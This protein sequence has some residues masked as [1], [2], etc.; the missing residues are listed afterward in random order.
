MRPGDRVG[1]A[2]VSGPLTVEQADGMLDGVRELGFEPV[3][4]ANLRARHDLFAGRDDERLTGLHE[5]AADPTLAAVVFARGGH[6][7]LPLLPR[8]DWE[9]LVA[10]PRAWVGYSD[11]T[12]F[13]LQWS[14]RSGY[15]AFH[16]PMGVDVARGLLPEER[17][18]LLASL[19]GEYPQV[20]SARRAI[21]GPEPARAPVAGTL[22]GGCLSLLAS[23]L[24]TPWQVGFEGA[25]L[26]LEDV[27]EPLYRIDRM[28]TH[29]ALSGSL[30]GVLGVVLGEL[31]GC[32][33]EGGAE[34]T[35]VPARVRRLL[36]EVPVL[37][38]LEFGHG[39]PNR[40]LPIGLGARIDPALR[41]LSLG[42]E[43]TA[44]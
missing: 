18:S 33:E 8:L 40:T 29:L 42:V 21:D 3:A 9:T 27:A 13:L 22:L 20:L 1:L 7:L 43:P 34:S 5:L 17:V 14:R 16:G 25:I 19:A 31:G 41:T 15:V 35:S 36:P 24:G 4:A 2:A 6:G 32:D 39:A 11:L 10:R 44:P 28:L 23:T 37:H 38:G 26:F 30:N 12:P